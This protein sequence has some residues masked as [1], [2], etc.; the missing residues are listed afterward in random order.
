MDCPSADV[1]SC[2][3][4]AVVASGRCVTRAYIT[5]ELIS[6]WSGQ[7]H[8]VA[9]T[10]LLARSTNLAILLESRCRVLARERLEMGEC[11]VPAS[12]VL[13]ED[14]EIHLR[15][16]SCLGDMQRM[17]VVSGRT[18]DLH[19]VKGFRIG[20][21]AEDLLEANCSEKLALI[22]VSTSKCSCG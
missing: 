6:P 20:S 13:H 19:N 3:N 9:N 11:L 15:L 1:H 2:I 5:K 17:L 18:T 14:V 22:A 21:A 10:M 7:M 4:K 16:G 8:C 12:A